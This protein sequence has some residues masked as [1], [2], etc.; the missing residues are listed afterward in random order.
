MNDRTVQIEKGLFPLWDEHITDTRHTDAELS[1]NRPDR[2]GSV[3]KADMPWEGNNSCSF[4]V[5]H[6]GGVYRMYYEGRDWPQTHKTYICLAESADGLE[7]T[8]PCI[9]KRPKE[10]SPSA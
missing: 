5:I 2:A 9:T 4:S 7:W 6:D 10:C 1:V 3:F 8:R